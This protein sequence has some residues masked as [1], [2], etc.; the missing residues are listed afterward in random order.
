MARPDFLCPRVS[1]DG[2]KRLSRAAT[3]K[4]SLGLGC[5]ICRHK[6]TFSAATALAGSLALCVALTTPS[7]ARADADADA[8]IS[9]LLQL[10]VQKKIVSPKQAKELFQETEGAPRAAHGTAPVEPQAEPAKKGEI[11]VTYVPQFIRRQIADEVRAQVLTE[12]QQEGWAAPNAL[13]EWARRIEPYG[14]LR[15][16]YQR[17][18][19]A[20]GNYNQFVNYA[21]VNQGSPF[22]VGELTANGGPLPPFLNTTEDRDRERV[23]ARIGLQAF[24]DD[25]W[26]A[27]I[28]V[29]TGADQGPVTPNQ[30]LGSPGDFSKYQAW[31][32]RAYFTYQ[33]F[34]DLTFYA[35]REP[36]PFFTTD[37]IFYSDLGFDGISFNYKPRVSNTVG[38]FLNGG[39]FP[40]L[41]TA[42][43]FSTNDDQKFGSANAYLL[44]IQ[45][46]A[47]WQI[48]QDLAAKL[49]VGFFDFTGVQGAVS[50]PCV[51]QPGSGTFNETFYCNT[52]NTRFPY[53]Q[54]G[55]TVFDIRNI[56][57]TSELPYNSNENSTPEYFGLA[58]RF[59]V[60]EI[61]PRVEIS[62]YDPI[63][64]SIEGEYLKNLAFNR[65]EILD[66]GPASV[67]VGPVNP[68]KNG[69]Y[70]GGPNA[71]VV[72]STIGHQEIHKRWDW[73]VTIGYKYLESDSTLDSINDADFHEGGTNAKG[74]ILTG[75]L[76]VAR[77]TYLSLRYFDAQVV[78]G[79]QYTEHTFQLD[80][81]STF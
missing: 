49:G 61:H 12:S 8:K 5:M 30:T 7:P 2:Q 3:G 34:K 17:D 60:L 27:N 41:N 71:Y 19:F 62:T 58:S 10:L 81:L 45:G 47:T 64:V 6:H 52:D 73:N 20:N 16:R 77:D 44:A 11:R 28:R 68:T 72:K 4:R 78:S 35:G 39:A 76:G 37:L 80:L 31:I 63:D 15:V 21:S 32:D 43:D 75:S 48:R 9:R 23:R 25:G 53:E 13:P 33:P 59:A 74:Y 65:Q 46:G 29:G 36:N 56:D 55:N 69:V 42:F 67:Q 57:T 22:D 14:D 24:I 66:H 40:I 54:F 79:P 38:L 26:T 70:Q 51:A 1:A 50:R 18:S